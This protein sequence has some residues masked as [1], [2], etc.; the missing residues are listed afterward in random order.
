MVY[1]Y[2][3][4]SQSQNITQT[5]LRKWLSGWDKRVKI[6]IDHNDI[7]SNLSN[8]PVLI[9]LSTSSGRN[10]DDVS[11]IFDEL[12]NDA[13]RKKIAVTT[14]DKTTQCYVEIEKWDHTG[15]QAWLW[16]KVPS[17]SNTSD[18]DLYWYYDNTHVDNDAYV[19]DTNDE[20]AENV[21]DSNFKL[22]THM[23]DNPDT[24][25]VR[26]STENDNDGTKVDIGEPAV[27]TSGEISD[28]QYFDG[29][30]DRLNYGS[31]TSLNIRDEV[32][33]ETW[34]NM[35]QDP[36]NNKWYEVIS[37]D[38][39]SLYLYENAS[40]VLLSAWFKINGTTFDLYD[41]TTT[42]INPNGWIRVVITFDGKDIKG[43][44]NGQLDGT[45]NKPGT[46]DDSSSQNLIIGDW[47][48]SENHHFDGKID[49]VRISNTARTL[50]WIKASYETGRDH[51]LDFGSEEV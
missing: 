43:Y 27:T 3:Y 17:L 26:D 12:Q 6:T 31:D 34:I 40:D 41:F 28:A 33:L 22:V 42:D 9:H 36:E 18:T 23:R 30:N 10:N 20:V 51:L 19:G 11:F 14:S 21:W 4:Q 46:I 5:I 44:V 15:E 1:A 2:V 47:S 7:D 45:Y 49:E 35:D 32:T 50:A 8:F 48:N 38:K 39:Y 25:H 13:N 37:K 24:S 16:V 29:D